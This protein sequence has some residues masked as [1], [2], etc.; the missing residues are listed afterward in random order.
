MDAADT[1]SEAWRAE[2]EARVVAAMPNHKTRKEYLDRVTYHRGTAAAEELR[3]A[4]WDMIVEP[5]MPDWPT[6]S[7]DDGGDG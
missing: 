3:Q 2:C 5:S 7:G 4:A 1:T 6:E